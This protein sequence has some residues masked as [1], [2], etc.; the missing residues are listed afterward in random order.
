[1]FAH[2]PGVDVVSPMAA[3][4]YTFC[5]ISVFRM[6]EFRVITAAAIFHEI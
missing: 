4:Q 6:S 3:S 5:E 1:M 2:A